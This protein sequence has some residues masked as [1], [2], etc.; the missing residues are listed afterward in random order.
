MKRDVGIPVIGTVSGA[1]ARVEFSMDR[2]P[3][4]GHTSAP[5]DLCDSCGEEFGESGEDANGWNCSCVHC[6][7]NSYSQACA[8][9]HKIL[10]E[11][12]WN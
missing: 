3:A 2:C 5:I 10:P 9:C 4:C 6:G 11:E 1:D 8:R 12:M 7:Q